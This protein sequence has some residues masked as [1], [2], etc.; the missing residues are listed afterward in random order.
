MLEL[1]G[2]IHAEGCTVVLKQFLEQKQLFE[3][4]LRRLYRCTQTVSGRTKI[5]EDYFK[6]LKLTLY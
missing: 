6:H 4:Y 2:C 5:F 1:D 3:D